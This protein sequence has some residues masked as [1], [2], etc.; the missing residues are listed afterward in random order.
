M[1]VCYPASST[2]PPPGLTPGDKYLGS[3]PTLLPTAKQQATLT[4]RERQ[5]SSGVARRPSTVCQTVGGVRLWESLTL[6][7]INNTDKYTPLSSVM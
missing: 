4:V 3:G 1:C 2:A 5:G 7:L 6:E